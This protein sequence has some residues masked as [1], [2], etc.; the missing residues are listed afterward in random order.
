MIE[1]KNLHKFFNKN[2][3]NEIH[4]IDD[5]T[6]S[7]PEKGMVAIFGKSGCGKTTLLNVIGGLDK[8]EKGSIT[9]DGA[10]INESTD[11][12]R[13]KY[14]GYIFQNYNLNKAESC[15][16]NVANALRLCGLTDAK[17]IEERTMA[18]LKNVGM[19]KYKKRTPD[20][21]SGG[22]QQRIAIA[23][24]IVKNPRIILAD[25]PTGNLDEQNTVMIM[26]LLKQISKDHL[27]ILVT[28]E[29]H[30]VDYYCDTVIELSDGKVVSL[31]HNSGADGY[32]TKNK[33]DI[34]LGEL[35]KQEHNDKNVSVEY[36]GSAPQAPIGIKLV[37]YMGK[38]YLKLDSET[39]QILDASS[40][41]KLKEG[42]F[43]EKKQKE[44]QKIDMSA[45][46]PLENGSKYGKLFDFRSSVVSGYQAIFGK[47]KRLN[48]V[49]RRTLGLFAVVLVIMSATL[50]SSIGKIENIQ[51]S[52]NP[53]VV[54]VIAADSSVSEKVNSL[55]GKH[56]ID[57]IGM[58]SYYPYYGRS[59]SFSAS[60]FETFSTYQNMDSRGIEVSAGLLEK[61]KLIEGKKE[62]LKNSEIVI[63]SAMADELLKSTTFGYMQKYSDLIGVR[64]ATEECFIAGIVESEE[65]L[66]FRNEVVLAK[67]IFNNNNI[68]ISVSQ[69]PSLKNG[70]VVVV[71]RN[72]NFSPEKFK[73]V[74]IRGES[75]EVAQY[76]NMYYSYIEFLVGQGYVPDSQMKLSYQEFIDNKIKESGGKQEYQEVYENGFPEYYEYRVEGSKIQFDPDLFIRKYI[77]DNYPQI[78]YESSEYYELYGQVWSEQYFNYYEQ[79]FSLLDEYIEYRYL[80]TPDLHTWIAME[81]DVLE[82]KLSLTGEDPMTYYNALMYA[83]ENNG[84]I[85]KETW[86][87]IYGYKEKYNQAITVYEKEYYDFTNNGELNVYSPMLFMVT[88]QDYIRIS[89][90]IGES[91][92]FVEYNKG[93]KPM[94][95]Y[96]IHTTDIESTEQ[97]MLDNFSDIVISTDD[98]DY[99]YED[100]DTLITPLE[101]FDSMLMEQKFEI[102]A[103]LVVLALMLALMSLCMYFIMRS[104]L[105]SRIKEI[106]VYR[107]I[108]VSKGNMLFKFFIESLVLTTL[109]VFIGYAFTSGL[110]FY[111]CSS[112]GMVEQM[113]YYPVWYASV[114]LVFIYGLCAICGLLPIFSLLRKTPSQI[115]AK[116]DI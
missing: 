51:D 65:K 75:F 115:L 114:V 76:R 94:L 57:Y 20:T 9:I 2:R 88:E 11:T 22:Q 6:L 53:N 5:I 38:L 52:V 90:M 68:S 58:I 93:Y 110:M 44:E 69:D 63:T 13:N 100:W 27:V 47:T 73:S 55:Y 85:I 12:V 26:D 7:L 29:A 30:L 48:K 105:M 41:I 66:I 104:T 34:W 107:A 14:I 1:L 49:M 33:N 70:Q 50:G 109:S 101:L 96:T 91:D 8:I 28:H 59:Y 112:S 39:V 62:G 92:E 116:Y 79:Y 18:A 97:F 37:N 17:E 36:Y 3:S 46:P 42:V 77:A 82:I 83:Q 45:L 71:D 95:Y 84:A 102:V 24:A 19:E 80:L 67:N 21:L 106:G 113:F 40:E 74:M 111:W 89:K 61:Y 31:R 25:E 35:E 86:E 99:Y 32:N 10:N 78:K 81:K 103:N 23:R 72:N 15:F 4:V 43:E 64:E 56:G 87:D 98:Y 54:Y 16:D 108:G 60:R